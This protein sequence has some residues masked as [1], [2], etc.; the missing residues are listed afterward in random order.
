MWAIPVMIGASHLGGKVCVYVKTRRRV[1]GENKFLPRLCPCS[2]HSGGKLL[3]WMGVL[4]SPPQKCWRG[5]ENR[6]QVGFRLFLMTWGWSTKL[7]VNAGLACG[8]LPSFPSHKQTP[9][10]APNLGSH[11][12]QEILSCSVTPY[13]RGLT[14]L[15]CMPG[16]ISHHPDGK[17][18]RTD[19][20]FPG[21]PVNV[22]ETPVIRLR[23]RQT[24]CKTSIPSHPPT[25]NTPPLSA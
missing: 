6:F 13:P 10:C 22:T 20:I 3:T 9:P 15:I 16:A 2:V 19:P 8:E 24:L 25:S 1:A 12:P 17:T 7:P 23:Q 14:P 5:T 18:P 4:G 11:K 21:S